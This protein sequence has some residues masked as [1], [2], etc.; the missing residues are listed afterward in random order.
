[1]LV[2][3]MLRIDIG[4]TFNIIPALIHANVALDRLSNFLYNVRPP[5]PPSRLIQFLT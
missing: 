1:M 2:F 3:D 5:F 4:A